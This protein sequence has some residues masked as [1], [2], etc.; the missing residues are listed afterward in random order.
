MVLALMFIYLSFPIAKRN[1]S[2]PLLTWS[3]QSAQSMYV[4]NFFFYINSISKIYPSQNVLFTASG[5]FFLRLSTNDIAVALML[6]PSSPSIQ[7]FPKV[8]KF[9]FIMF[10]TPLAIIHWCL[11]LWPKLESQLIWLYCAVSSLRAGATSVFLKAQPQ[12]LTDK[13]FLNV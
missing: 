1:K 4:S 3:L 11:M 8:S 5:Y 9:C 13:Y 6:S 2:K 12:D 10:T 7:T